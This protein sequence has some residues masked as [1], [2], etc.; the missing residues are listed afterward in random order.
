MATENGNNK[1]RDIV[2]QWNIFN[3]KIIVA[4]IRLPFF[5]SGCVEFSLFF[6]AIEDATKQKSIGQAKLVSITS[7]HAG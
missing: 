5:T 6:L 4:S 2:A 3:W 7:Q 1:Q